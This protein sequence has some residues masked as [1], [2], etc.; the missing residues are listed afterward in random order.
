LSGSADKTIRKWDMAT[1]ACMAVLEGHEGT[2][3]RIICTGDFIFSSSYDR[4]ARCWDFDSGEFVREFRGHRRSVYPLL[5]IPSPDD[6]EGGDNEE[7]SEN[8]D[9][10]V[11]GS[12]DRTRTY[13]LLVQLT[14]P[15]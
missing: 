3:N 2:V 4:T 6:D 5:F 10:L 15:Q 1:C 9:V 13:W 12:A 11:T 14:S 7:N 8:Q